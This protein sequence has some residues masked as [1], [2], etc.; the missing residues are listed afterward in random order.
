MNLMRKL[1]LFLAFIGT[2]G[3]IDMSYPIFLIFYVGIFIMDYF[4]WKKGLYEERVG[5]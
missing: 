2:V 3:T 1:M 4:Y 5:T